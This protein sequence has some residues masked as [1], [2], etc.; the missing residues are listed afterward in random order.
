MTSLVFRFALAIV[1]LT[2]CLA[3]ARAADPKVIPDV[4]FVPPN[5]AAAL[6]AL[7]L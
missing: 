7:T 3:P 1:A 6:S 4:V 2:T 5:D